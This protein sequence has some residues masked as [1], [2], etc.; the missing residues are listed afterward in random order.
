MN[1]APTSRLLP[2]HPMAEKRDR[3]RFVS[4]SPS[5]E[6]LVFSSAASGL[7]V[8]LI[9]VPDVRQG[10]KLERSKSIPI[11]NEMKRTSSELQLAE[12]EEVADFRDYLLFSR[13]VDGIT[14]QQEMTK[15]FGSRLVNDACLAHIIGVRNLS[16][17]QLKKEFDRRGH[18]DQQQQSRHQHCLADMPTK[19]SIEPTSLKMFLEQ[20][21]N[22]AQGDDEM[23]TLEL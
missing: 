10:S 3:L 4:P 2:I 11:R 14:R 1:P 23:F 19:T 16:E 17:D 6:K 21:Y 12:E 5:C 8:P 20:S 9:D 7:P 15:D 22:E 18:E 13:I